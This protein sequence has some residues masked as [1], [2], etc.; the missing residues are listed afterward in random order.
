MSYLSRS[1][2][3]LKEELKGLDEKLE[4]YKSMN[5]SLDMSRG[6]PGYD[7]LELSQPLLNNPFSDGM[8]TADGFDTRNYGLPDGVPECRRLFAD[9]LDV[10]DENILI[11]GNASLT[12]MYDYI[13]QC[14]VSGV[15]GGTPWINQRDIKFLCPVPGYDR[16]FS[17]LESFGIGMINIPML[18]DGP[19][20][21]LVEKYVK[22]EKVKGLICTPKYS[23]PTGI[24]FSNECVHRF[25]A[26]K[27]A[28]RDFRVIWDNAYCVHDL[29]DS[30]R[31]YLP[32]ILKVSREYG[33]EDLFIEVAS[34]S[35]I[36]F[37]GAGVAA[38]AASVKNVEAIR[39]RQKV[40]TICFDKINQLRH[41]HFL[42]NAAGIREHMKLHAQI[43]R[44]KFAAVLNVLSS[45]LD[46]QGIAEWNNPRGGYFINLIVPEGCAKRVI[47][48]CAEAGVKL[49]DAGAA[50]PYHWDEK[51]SQ[52]RIAPSYPDVEELT[53]AAQVLCV[54]IKKA[55]AEKALEI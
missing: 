43:L 29:Y 30:N 38:L 1:W 5:L 9:M 33:N 48:L 35:K 22:Y 19:D 13:T 4:E 34:T 46:G 31:D 36:T 54:C 41:A 20:M 49:T 55:A 37:P 3:E 53:L 42:K 44:P 6:K 27:P 18:E 26:L 15:D 8:K 23:N 39:E 24:T 47:S 10:D 17:I 40:Q 14:M 21:D 51:D 45:E 2:D 50:F 52:I 25:A 12:V 11:F 32:S 28:A 7:Q 16:H